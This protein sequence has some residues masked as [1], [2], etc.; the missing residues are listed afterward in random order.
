MTAAD[1]NELV[2]RLFGAA[3]PDEVAV[4]EHDGVRHLLCS[5]V[6]ASGARALTNAVAA[7]RRRHRVIAGARADLDAV[8]SAVRDAGFVGTVDTCTVMCLINPERGRVRV[9]TQLVIRRLGEADVEDIAA[10]AGAAGLE[11]PFP[12]DAFGSAIRRFMGQPSFGAYVDARLVALLGSYLASDTDF[13]IGRGYVMPIWRGNGIL[14]ELTRRL[15]HHIR[16]LR[17]EMRIWGVLEAGNL[18]SRRSLQS[19]GFHA[20]GELFVA[21][22]ASEVA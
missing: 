10:L 6:D 15:C 8:M 1:V 13:E 22:I 20:V 14:G 18:A 17:P 19:A 2:R 7:S 12:A 4:C 9:S 16:A 5:G 11:S 3:G 21:T